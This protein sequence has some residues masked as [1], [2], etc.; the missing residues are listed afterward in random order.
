M[1]PSRESTW[2]QRQGDESRAVESGARDFILPREAWMPG[3]KF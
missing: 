3:F 1:K 2:G